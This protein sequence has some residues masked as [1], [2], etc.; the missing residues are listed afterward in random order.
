MEDTVL[1]IVNEAREEQPSNAPAPMLLK[2]PFN[3]NSVRFEQ[4]L[5]TRSPMESGFF[6][7]A[8]VR[9]KVRVTLSSAEQPSNALSPITYM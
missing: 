9:T 4:P 7:Y 3:T 5:N 2:G 8:P 6:A 1:G